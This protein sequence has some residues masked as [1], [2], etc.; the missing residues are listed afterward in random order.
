MLAV[1]DWNEIYNIVRQQQYILY[2]NNN[3]NN[4]NDFVDHGDNNYNI[5]NTK[6]AT[7]TILTITTTC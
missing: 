7:T 1:M 2:G 4:T 6:A 3:I 5:N